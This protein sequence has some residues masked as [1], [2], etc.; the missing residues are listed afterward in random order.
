MYIAPLELQ[1]I[2]KL[3][4][5]GFGQVSL[6]KEVTTGLEVAVKTIS[7]QTPGAIADAEVEKAAL[8][9]LKGHPN[10]IQVKGTNQKGNEY[11]VVMEYM[12]NSKDLF[13]QLK[14]YPPN[15]PTPTMV[16]GKILG[17]L[18]SA[19]NYCHDKNIA[20]R[21][22]KLE[23][24]LVDPTTC[25]LKLIDFGLAKEAPDGS[26]TQ[27][28]VGTS[29]YMAP[30][31]IRD[32]KPYEAKKTDIWSLGVLL[33]V[34]ATGYLP[35]IA[36]ENTTLTQLIKEGKYEIPSFVDVQLADLIRSMLQTDPANRISREDF[37]NHP[38]CQKYQHFFTSPAPPAASA[39]DAIEAKLDQQCEI[40]FTPQII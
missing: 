18:A 7:T 12:P 32:E 21:D 34:L 16:I 22:L 37:K 27:E 2:K 39:P 17:Q 28:W 4:E 31:V 36:T 33:F 1:S 19:V 24:V 40:T 25:Q 6:C 23:N 38:F 3:G 5:G 26:L 29:N 14:K 13:D 11:L 9:K 35:F 30:E 10:I 8:E 20:H 15:S